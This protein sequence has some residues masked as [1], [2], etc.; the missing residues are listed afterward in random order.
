[1][2]LLKNALHPGAVLKELYLHPLNMG[3]IEFA[4]RLDVPRTRIE[5]L[6]KG[7]TSM[8]PDTAM[9]LAQV[10]GTTPI[11]WMS[12]QTNYDMAMLTKKLDVSGIEPL[13]A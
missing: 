11:Y 5:R 6:I 4:R 8:T 7:T 2:N 1:M 12:M 9:R 13:V 3:A 10:F